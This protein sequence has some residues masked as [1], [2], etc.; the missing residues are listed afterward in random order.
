MGRSAGV[1]VRPAWC[2]SGVGPVEDRSRAGLAVAGASIEAEEECADLRGVPAIRDMPAG[3]SRRALL[4]T[5]RFERM[6][7]SDRREFVGRPRS[8]GRDFDHL[9]RSLLNLRKISDSNDFYRPG[10]P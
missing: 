6:L 5:P 10:I 1:R 4:T 2:G 9:D 3:V 7:R 8:T